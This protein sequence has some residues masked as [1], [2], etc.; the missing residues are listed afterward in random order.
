MKI[1]TDLLNP[2][3]STG[4]Y[5][6][7]LGRN[8]RHWEAFFFLISPKEWVKLQCRISWMELILTTCFTQGEIKHFKK[9]YSLRRNLFSGK[10]YA[11]VKYVP[12]TWRPFWEQ[13]IS[14]HTHIC[15]G[16]IENWAFFVL[17][18]KNQDII[19]DFEPK[20]AVHAALCTNQ[21]SR[22]EILSPSI[23]WHYNKEWSLW[24]QLDEQYDSANLITR[25]E[26][27]LSS[28]LN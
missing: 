24:R 10:V 15:S 25:S 3:S 21:L 23:P 20:N 22:S 6:C 5:Q 2:L 9:Y 12:R 16:G 26:M 27:K 11:F 8:L 13:I 4:A 17:T 14:L 28:A 19:W 18:W 1:N 7:D